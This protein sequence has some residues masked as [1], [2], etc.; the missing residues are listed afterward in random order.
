MLS[1][2]LPRIRSCFRLLYLD[3]ISVN[4]LLR[5]CAANFEILDYVDMTMIASIEYLHL[6]TYQ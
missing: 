2:A 3:T 5:Y 1:Y 6:S 4:W